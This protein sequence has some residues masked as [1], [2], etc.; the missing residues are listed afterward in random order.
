MV[1]GVRESGWY[2]NRRSGEGE[3]ARGVRELTIGPDTELIDSLAGETDRKNGSSECRLK[4]RDPRLELRL[5]AGLLRLEGVTC[6]L[7]R[8]AI[9]PP[10]LFGVN[11]RVG[12]CCM[13]RNRLPEGLITPSPF[14]FPLPFPVLKSG[15]D[16]IVEVPGTKSEWRRAD[17]S[18]LPFRAEKGVVAV[19]SWMVPGVRAPVARVSCEKSDRRF[20]GLWKDTECVDF[21]VSGGSSGTRLVV[22]GVGVVVRDSIDNEEEWC[23]PVLL[24]PLPVGV[25]RGLLCFASCVCVGVCC[26]AVVTGAEYVK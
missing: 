7:L 2:V 22:A 11:L 20:S 8:R 1:M 24:L 6:T 17:R 13:S 16:P 18:R 19:R 23:T 26:G 10:S 12:V 15:R 4:S 25:A 21:G 9:F 5:S 14:A 3:C